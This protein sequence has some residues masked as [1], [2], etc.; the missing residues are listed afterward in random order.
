MELKK[1]IFALAFSGVL[2]APNFAVAQ[3]QPVPEP[4]DIALNT[5]AFQDSFY[6]ALKQK[7]IE[8]YDRAVEALEKCQTMQPNNPVVFSSSARITSR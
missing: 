1:V 3:V 2:I 7:G 6:E 8:N 4:D 5:D